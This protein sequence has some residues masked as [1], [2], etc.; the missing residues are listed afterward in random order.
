VKTR[1]E[2]FAAWFLGVALPLAETARRRTDF[3][4]PAA[5]IDDFL[6]GGLLLWAAWAVTRR[7]PYGPGLLA[8]AWGVLSG[9]MY[10]SFFEQLKRLGAADV[11]GLPGACVIAV[12]GVTFA[13]ALTGLYRSARAIRT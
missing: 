1:F 11:S 4:D 9:A 12:K 6:I 10:Y 13:V 5:Y 7:R 3:S 8:A 2:V